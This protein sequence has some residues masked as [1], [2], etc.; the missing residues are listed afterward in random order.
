[1]YETEPKSFLQM[2][3]PKVHLFRQFCIV[4]C[5]AQQ[6]LVMIMLQADPERG[7]ARVGIHTYIFLAIT[8]LFPALLLSTSFG[9][10]QFAETDKFS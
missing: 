9:V 2:N 6:L 8:W 10:Q 7:F 1:M 3:F 4:V 5:V